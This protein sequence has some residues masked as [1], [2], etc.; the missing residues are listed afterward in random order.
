[1]QSV[2]MNLKTCVLSVHDLLRALMSMR[3]GGD[4]GC[5]PSGGQWRGLIEMWVNFP[6]SIK[7]DIRLFSL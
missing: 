6:S 1:M 7:R 3:Y 4:G 5:C 2:S